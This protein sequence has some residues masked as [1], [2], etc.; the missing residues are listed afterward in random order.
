MPMAMILGQPMTVKMRV[1]HAFVIVA[2]DVP[3]FAKQLHAEQTAES[4]EHESDAHFRRHSEWIGNRHTEDKDDGSDHQKNS[5]MADA[6]AEPHQTRSSPRRPLREHR[7]DGDKMVRIQGMT[8][9]E[10]EP[11]A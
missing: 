9:S 5:G 2:M 8:Q 7:R 1:P 3:P 6:P 10:H 4:D 11:Q